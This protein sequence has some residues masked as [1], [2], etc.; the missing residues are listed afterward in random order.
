MTTEHTARSTLLR[1]VLDRPVSARTA[2][3]LVL[4]VLPTLVAGQNPPPPA[5][6]PAAL[7]QAVSH[8]PRLPH[9]IRPRLTKAGM[10]P[11]QSRAR[12]QASRSPPPRLAAPPG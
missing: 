6:A 5:Q 4:L 11:A 8:N 1:G 10:P 12:L 3:C 2:F 9:R 7:Q